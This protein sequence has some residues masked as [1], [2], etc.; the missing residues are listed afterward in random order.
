LTDE[1]ELPSEESAD[2]LV[3]GHMGKFQSV[4]TGGEGVSDV[5][6]YQENPATLSLW[7]RP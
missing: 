1:Q 6:P 3:G 4:T 5:W 2:D 7:R